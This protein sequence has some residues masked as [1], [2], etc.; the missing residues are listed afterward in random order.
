M[1]RTKQAT[2]KKYVAAVKAVTK[3]KP[4]TKKSTKERV[5]KPY[6][7]HPGTVALR[8]IRKY[9]SSTKDILAKKPFRDLVFDVIRESYYIRDT[10]YRFTKTALEALKVAS[11][12]MLINLFKDAQETAIHC[13][14]IG[15]TAADIRHV[16]KIKGANWW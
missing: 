1:V 9:Q 8:E 13:N 11:E 15:I 3:V 14:H 2:P 10:D 6:R 7:Y 12:D 4:T 5:R 16:R